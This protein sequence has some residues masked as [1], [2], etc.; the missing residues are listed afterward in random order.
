MMMRVQNE[1]RPQKDKERERTREKGMKWDEVLADGSPWGDKGR[2]DPFC[3]LTLAL[4]FVS[5]NHS[6]LEVFS[7]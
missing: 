7:G 1:R 2:L 3:C 4:R 5:I 6:S